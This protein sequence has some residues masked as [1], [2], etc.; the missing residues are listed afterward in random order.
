MSAVGEERLEGITN[1]Y[2]TL[3]AV[4]LGVILLGE[5]YVIIYR[6]RF[7]LDFSGYL[8]FITQLLVFTSRLMMG[9]FSNEDLFELW[10]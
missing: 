7:K 3:N 4:Y 2:K 1:L 8:I 6:L 9:G 10:F 5:I